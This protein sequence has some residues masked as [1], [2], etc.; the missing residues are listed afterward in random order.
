[1]LAVAVRAAAR[2]WLSLQGIL[3]TSIKTIKYKLFLGIEKTWHT[4][5]YNLITEVLSASFFRRGLHQAALPPSVFGKQSRAVATLV[6]AVRGRVSLSLATGAS[7][8]N[9]PG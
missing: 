7:H 6:F 9:G 2:E 5:C 1:M 8:R 4:G 3:I